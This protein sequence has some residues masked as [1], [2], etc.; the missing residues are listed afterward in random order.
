[1]HL[2]TVVCACDTAPMKPPDT[3]NKTHADPGSTSDTGMLA[4]PVQSRCRIL[5]VDD[6]A[7]NRLLFQVF[8][9]N[10]DADIEYAENGVQALKLFV[11]RPYDIILMDMHMPLMNGIDT[12]KAIRVHEEQQSDDSVARAVILAITA[13]DSESDHRRSLQAGCDEHLVKPVSRTTLINI[14][15]G[16][17]RSLSTIDD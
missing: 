11:E 15:Q 8:L 2:P 4:E 3:T 5:V 10:Q 13:D 17:C 16:H 14:L 1:M 6:S 9:K 12:T 7:D